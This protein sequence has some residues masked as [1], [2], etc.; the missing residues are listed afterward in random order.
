MYR[1]G[2]KHA[3]PVGKFVNDQVAALCLVHCGEDDEEA[4]EVA[5]PEGLWF[6]N[7]AEELYRPWQ[8]R[9][10]PDSYKF[11]VNAVQQERVDKTAQ[12]HLESG[13]FAMGNPDTVIK[14]LRKYQEAGVDQVLCFMQMGNLEHYRIM[15]SIKLFGRQVIPFFQ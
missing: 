15:E 8:G 12:D 2:L 7:K 1:E 4:R 11:S 14:V 13:A 9:E 10:V 3:H 5:A 6:V